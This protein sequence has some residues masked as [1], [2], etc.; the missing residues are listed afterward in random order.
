MLRSTG[1]IESHI[2]NIIAIE[3]LY[4]TIYIVGTFGVAMESDVGEIGLHES[5]LHVGDTHLGMSHIDAQAVGNSLDSSFGGT[6]YITSG[7]SGITCH[8]TDVDDMPMV[9]LHHARHDESGHGEESLDVGV[10]HLVPVLEI[11]FILRFQATSQARVVDQHV[12]VAPR[13]GDI[14]YRFLGSL[15]VANVESQ[16]Q[17][18]HTFFFE[19]LFQNLQF[20]GVS[21]CD[22]EIVTAFGKAASATFADT[23]SCACD[24]S[25]FIHF[26]YN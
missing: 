1:S 11:T 18:L 8:T 21:T 2:G 16:C 26:L 15:P 12:D 25:Y 6:I 19:F 7:I 20:P 9:A 3:R 13:L 17:H 10:N 22:N 5:R 24:E 14:V 4:A 23:A